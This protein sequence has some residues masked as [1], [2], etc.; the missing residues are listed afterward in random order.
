MLSLGCLELRVLLS[1]VDLNN[2]TGTPLL[3]KDGMMKLARDLMGEVSDEML[4]TNVDEEEDGWTTLFNGGHYPPEVTENI[5]RCQAERET[6]G[7]EDCPDGSEV[8]DP[9]I[10][11]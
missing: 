5:K 3:D 10:M 11:T 8:W 7:R 2:G 4:V 1:F 9:S 6:S